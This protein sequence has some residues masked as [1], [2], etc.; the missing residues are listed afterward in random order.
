[1]TEEKLDLILKQQEEILG[2]LRPQ[3]KERKPRPAVRFEEWWKA[4]PTNRRVNKK[5]CLTKWKAR[6]LD[7]I[8]DIIIAD[9]KARIMSD[10]QW[11]DG[12]IPQ[13]TTYMNQ[14]RWE[15]EIDTQRKNGTGITLDHTSTD[16]IKQVND[17][18]W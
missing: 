6:K 5:G 12:F 1:M 4:Y 2:Y 8:A 9:T 3:N 7:N 14:S 17:E 18:S 11:L 10:V 13:T 16:W 15:S